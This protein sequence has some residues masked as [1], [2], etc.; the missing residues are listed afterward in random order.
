MFP[1]KDLLS[2]E[3]TVALEKG[4]QWFKSPDWANGEFYGS[5]IINDLLNW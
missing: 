3:S 1:D 4:D 5:E 2:S